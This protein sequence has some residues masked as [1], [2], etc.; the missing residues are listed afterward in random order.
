[1]EDNKIVVETYPNGFKHTAYLYG[2]IK[3]IGDYQELISV[4]R[5]AGEEDT[6]HIVINT[7]GGD[8][9]ATNEIISEMSNTAAHVITE[10]NGQCS[11]GGSAIFLSSDEQRVGMF[12]VMMVHADSHG[13]GGADHTL[14]DYSDFSRKYQAN[15]VNSI[16]KDF[17]SDEE[18][19]EA[20]R[21]KEFWFDSE[22]I[23]E[24]LNNRALL[25]S[26][27]KEETTEEG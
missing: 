9:Y 19:Q 22:E 21:G 13:Y 6:V 1:M 10:S 23:I 2:E 18:L 24:R 27:D 16:Y 8:Q 11:S 7:N 25:Q 4:L 14:H 5:S 20:I 3:E 15:W 17:L 26:G 12:M